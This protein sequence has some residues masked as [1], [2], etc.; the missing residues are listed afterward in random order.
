MEMSFIV[1]LYVEYGKQ[2]LN[3][4]TLTAEVDAEN[5]LSRNVFEKMEFDKNEHPNGPTGIL[6]EWN[7]KEA[8]K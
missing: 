5:I 3:T 1:K 4:N 8:T 7:L 2:I 6:Y